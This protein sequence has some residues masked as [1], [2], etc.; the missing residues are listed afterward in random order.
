MIVSTDYLSFSFSFDGVLSLMSMTDVVQLASG[1][2]D[3]TLNDAQAKFGAL[4]YSPINKEY[5]PDAG[6]LILDK[7]NS[8]FTYSTFNV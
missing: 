4:P 1:V 7:P 8:T 2:L 3:V 6:Y 5:L